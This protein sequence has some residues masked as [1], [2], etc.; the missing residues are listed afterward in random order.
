[1]V[2]YKT[3]ALTGTFSSPAICEFQTPNTYADE[4]DINDK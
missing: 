1:V 4:W 2:A 3:V